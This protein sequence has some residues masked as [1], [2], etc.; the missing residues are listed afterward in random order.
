MREF[1][2][3]NCVFW[4]L[5]REIAAKKAEISLA[6]RQDFRLGAGIPGLQ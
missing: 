4:R 5:F 1:S 6:F 3:A 2:A